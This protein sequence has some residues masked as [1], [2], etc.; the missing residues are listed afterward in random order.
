MLIRIDSSN[1][2]EFLQ[3]N[4]RKRCMLLKLSEYSYIIGISHWELMNLK[5]PVTSISL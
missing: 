3:I 4:Y 2:G 1:L 5:V